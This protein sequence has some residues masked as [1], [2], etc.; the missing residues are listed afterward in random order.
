MTVVFFQRK[1]FAHQFS[2]EKVFEGI[3]QELQQQTSVTVE[4]KVMPHHST[5]ILPRIK[6]I[7]W[8]RQHQGDINHITGDVHYIALGLAKR[9]TILTLHDLNFLNHRLRLTRWLLKLFWITLPLKRVSYVTVI[10]EATRQDLLSR[11]VFPEERVR[12]IPN[13]Y[14]R[15]FHA[16][17]KKF[18]EDCPRI[19][20]IGTKANKNV[21]RLIRALEGIS[22]HLVIVGA[23]SQALREY[24]KQF[25]IS[26][27]WLQNLTD[28]QLRE[29]Y[30][31]CDI[32]SFVS[33][34]E[35]FGMP[36]V[37]SQ[38]TGRVVITSNVSSMPEVGGDSAHYVNPF[39]VSSIRSG[40][41]RLRDDR[42]Y[43]EKLIA[44]GF[45]NLGRYDL[46]KI[47]SLYMAFYLDVNQSS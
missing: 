27:T 12:V 19:L 20:Q 28:E 8:A 35:G 6:N 4:V 15:S 46:K 44:N 47:T 32:V 40:I 18:N 2:I 29:Q 42:N 21:P 25:R 1:P 23:E 11:T 34:I 45:N 14:D 36:I 10:S 30:A 37:E 26:Y 9:K 7:L 33:T 43:R 5:G 39:E 24:L 38:A 41:I 17:P 31:L 22:C 3:R 16:V 13:Y